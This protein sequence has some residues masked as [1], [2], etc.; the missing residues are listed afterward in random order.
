MTAVWG[1]TP[2]R[3][4]SPPE[5]GSTTS[6]SSSDGGAMASSTSGVRRPR[7][8][9]GAL[10]RCPPRPLPRDPRVGNPLSPP[11]SSVLARS[12]SRSTL[13]VPSPHSSHRVPSRRRPPYALPRPLARACSRRPG[14]GSC[15]ISPLSF[16]LSLTPDGTPPGTPPSRPMGPLLT[17]R[18]TPPSRPLEPPSHHMGP[19]PYP[20]S[21]PHPQP[22]PHP[23][24]TGPMSGTA[25][26]QDASL[27]SHGN[28]PSH[29]MR[30]LP[31][32]PWDPSLTPHGTLQM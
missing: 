6:R 7:W 32:S 29:L 22:Q 25:R 21:H 1:P 27:T 24:S 19:L 5:G 20:Q 18:G 3:A 12:V 4:E 2:L 28:S 26:P 16:P 10:A 15:E 30:P 9:C 14:D 31:H 13:F 11:V 17:P 23:C 8:R